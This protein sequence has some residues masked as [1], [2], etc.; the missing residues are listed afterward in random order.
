VEFISKGQFM[1]DE[2]KA[3]RPA[4]LRKKSANTER[5]PASTAAPAADKLE[6]PEKSANDNSLA[7]PLIPFPDGWYG[8]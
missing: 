4:A 1:A 3:R 2:I 6:C 8:G 7:W 5:Q